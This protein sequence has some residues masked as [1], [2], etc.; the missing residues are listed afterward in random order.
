MTT[1]ATRNTQDTTT[2]GTLFVAFEL[3]LTFPY[4]DF[5]KYGC[6]FPA[7]AS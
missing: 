7:D 5:S 6:S 4:R 2:E 1:Q 3:S